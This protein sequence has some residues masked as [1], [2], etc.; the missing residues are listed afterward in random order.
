M[1]QTCL[2]QGM[3]SPK[4]IHN[5]ATDYRICTFGRDETLQL[6][7]IARKTLFLNGKKAVI[8]NAVSFHHSQHI[9][10]HRLYHKTVVF[11][12]QLCE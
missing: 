12:N 5:R 4:P 6:F 1:K 11:E 9:G 10:E 8:V 3:K 7:S 2:C